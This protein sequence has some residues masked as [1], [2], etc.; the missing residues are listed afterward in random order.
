MRFAQHF[1]RCEFVVVWASVGMLLELLG[2]AIQAAEVDYLTQVKPILQ[3]HCYACHG[4]L[5]QRGGLRLDTVALAN[6][7]GESGPAIVGG[8]LS[9]S[10]A[11][12]AVTGQAGFEMPPEGEGVPLSEPEMTLLRRWIAQGA[13]AVPG[14]VPAEDPRKFWSYLVPQ[15]PILPPA[16][17]ESLGNPVDR[18]L[19]TQRKEL[20]LVPRPAAPPAV[21]L[22]RLY[23]DLIGLP[24]TR[25]E[26]RRF[27]AAPTETNYSQI[28]DTLL[29]RPEYGERWGRHWMDVWRYSD[30]YG[31]NNEIRYGQRGIWRWR[32]WIVESLNGDKPYDRMVAEMLAGD[33]LAPG[34][35]SV[36]RATGY[37]GRNWYKFDR[38]VWMFDTVEHAG[39]AFLGLTLR[40]CRCHDHKYDPLA[41][42]DY[43]RFRAFF[44]PHDV[45]T[46]QVPGAPEK[47]KDTT[48]GQVLKNGL[49]R[50]YDKNTDAPTFRFFRGDGRYPDKEHP[51]EPGVPPALGGETVEVRGID[52]P[53]DAFYPALRD[54]AVAETL[55]VTEGKVTVVSQAVGDA[56][57]KHRAAVAAVASAVRDGLATDASKVKPFMQERFDAGASA[58]WDIKSGAWRFGQ[59]TLTQS[60]VTRFA[61][62]VSKKSHPRDFFARVRYLTLKAGGLRSV[63]FSYDY[64]DDGGSSQDIYTST[65][66]TSPSVQAFHR[67]GGRQF[68]PAAGVV[69]TPIELGSETTVEIE[70]RGQAL[71]IWL[72]GEKKLQY[73]LPEN[74]A[75]GRFSLW[76]HEGAAEFREVTIRSLRATVTDLRRVAADAGHEVGVAR[77]QL[78]IAEC[79]HA[80]VQARVAAERIK[81]GA[82]PDKNEVSRSA[83]AAERSEAV[84]LVAQAELELLQARRKSQLLA[85]TGR[86]TNEGERGAAD[87]AIA[88]AEKKWATA[89]SRAD[90]VTGKY[91][92]L[93]TVYPRRSSG[94]R[95]ALARWIGSRQNPRTARIAVNHLWLRHFGAALVPSVANLGLNGVPPTHPRLLDWLAVE[96]MQGGWRM[97]RMH[98]LLVHSRSY[99]MASTAG[100]MA[101]RNLQVDPDNQ[102][103]WRMNSRRAEAETVRD[104]LLAV[105]GSL[106]LTMGG[107]EI[108][109]TSGEEIYRRSLYFRLTPNEKM[110][111][112][113]VFDVADPNACYRRQ[114]SVIPQQALALSNSRLALEQAQRLA[115]RLRA[116]HPEAVRLVEAGFEV[117]LSRPVEE[118]ELARCVEFLATQSQALRQSGVADAERRAAG[119]LIH[120]LLNHNDFVTIR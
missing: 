24:P 68:Y 10:L 119:N 71:T 91:T 95:L 65:N 64:R 109:E 94:R 117:V 81:Y 60:Q 20:G 47:V 97:K 78:K 96:F 86:P 106:D 90:R 100:S 67:K 1:L 115:D 23:L 5:R 50:I 25:S 9:E 49:A 36:V 103:L 108:A 30:W 80:S 101:G 48:F 32:D 75:E 62:V 112:L 99:R 40:C 70:V 27:L 54:D 34:D 46:E 105:C 37:L 21:L 31:S 19:Q 53:L 41:Q 93:G 89:Q 45:L 82:A 33:E 79:E 3:K 56:E 87:M 66:D 52:L 84:L 120:V 61:T 73:Q 26:L 42:V 107:P 35:R 72:N 104:S 6:R 7:G 13:R 17:T 51:L 8:N 28:V 4:A 38:N 14:E 118:T 113:E 57:Q 15:R 76:V 98:R 74:R 63:G 77:L 11:Y 69:R 22:R 44:E 59:G 18:F 43:Y 85:A 58:R 116:L 2:V 83:A 92:P 39:R 29:A 55:A 110:K 111:M 102:F 114:V 16:A 88:A 12:Q